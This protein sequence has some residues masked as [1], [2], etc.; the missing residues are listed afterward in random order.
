LN[1]NITTRRLFRDSK[2]ISDLN[3]Q[4]DWGIGSS[5]YAVD[6]GPCRIGVIRDDIEQLRTLSESISRQHGQLA[7]ASSLIYAS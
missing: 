1:N 2:F 3:P 6:W 4:F 7:E 5:S